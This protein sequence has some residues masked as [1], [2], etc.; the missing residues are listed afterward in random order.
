MPR[1][2]FRKGAGRPPGATVAPKPIRPA[3]LLPPE[4][5]GPHVQRMAREIGEDLDPL[6]VMQANMEFYHEQSGEILAT[7]MAM[8]AMQEWIAAAA[9]EPDELEELD[10]EF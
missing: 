9:S 3:R 7:I 4:H 2:G 6:E 1:G 10:V 8:P 5:Q